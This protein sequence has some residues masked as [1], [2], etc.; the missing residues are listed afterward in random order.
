MIHIHKL[1]KERNEKSIMIYDMVY[2]DEPWAT[3]EPMTPST[4]PQL[5][6]WVGEGG[7]IG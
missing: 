5:I 4:N 6:G 2:I 1:K 3:V 7:V